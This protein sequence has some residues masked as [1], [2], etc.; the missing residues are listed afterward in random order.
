[1]TSSYKQTYLLNMNEFEKNNEFFTNLYFWQY[2]LVNFFMDDS[3]SSM[4]Y[5]F[6]FGLDIDKKY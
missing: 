6:L 2:F 4:N 5:V 1:M 3:L